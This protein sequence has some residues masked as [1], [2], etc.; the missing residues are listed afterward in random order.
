LIWIKA[1]AQGRKLLELVDEA[2]GSA[3][4]RWAVDGGTIRSTWGYA[5]AHGD[6]GIFLPSWDE[7]PTASANCAFQEEAGKWA[8]SRKKGTYH[9]Q[10]I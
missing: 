8:S 2:R 10:P 9:D 4:V 1:A 5:T 6:P 3:K 7:L